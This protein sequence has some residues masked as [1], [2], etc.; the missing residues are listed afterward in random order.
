M[1]LEKAWRSLWAGLHVQVKELR[2]YC[3]KAS[4]YYQFCPQKLWRRCFS[5]S[6]NLMRSAMGNTDKL[7]HNQYK[8]ESNFGSVNI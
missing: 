5:F 8:N 3:V 2:L 6:I 1:A 4:G 7:G